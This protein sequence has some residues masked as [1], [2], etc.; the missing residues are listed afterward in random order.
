MILTPKLLACCGAAPV[1][2]VD[3]LEADAE[4]RIALRCIRLALKIQARSEVNEIVQIRGQ[5][6]QVRS[7][8]KSLKNG[9]NRNV[10][11]F[12]TLNMILLQY[13]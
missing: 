9:R 6:I 5:E 11:F 4:G 10:T 12:F 8:V 7:E 1:L 2:L 13:M 3:E